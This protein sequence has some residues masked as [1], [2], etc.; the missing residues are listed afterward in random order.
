VALLMHLLPALRVLAATLAGW[1]WPIAG[2]AAFELLALVHVAMSDDRLDWRAYLVIDGALAAL[3]LLWLSAW[4]A[5]GRR[6]T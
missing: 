1:R 3:A 5:R 4:H 6:T 2:A